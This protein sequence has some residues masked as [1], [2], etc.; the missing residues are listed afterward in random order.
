MQWEG[1]LL[2][3][4]NHYETEHVLT[5]GHRNVCRDQGSLYVFHRPREQKVENDGLSI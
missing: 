4:N 2:V 3:E 1:E 5:P